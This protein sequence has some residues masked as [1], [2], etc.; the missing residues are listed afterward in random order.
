VTEL[1]PDA[2]RVDVAATDFAFHADLP[3]TAGRYSFVMA[4]EGEAP[5]IMI[6]IQLAE[7]ATLAEVAASEGE[8]GVA[9]SFESELATPGAEAVLTTDLTPGT[10]ILVCPLPGPAGQTHADLGMVHEF[11]VA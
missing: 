10:W 5:H 2:T 1:D 6:L 7:G 9:A 3:T 11:T 4:N 8:E